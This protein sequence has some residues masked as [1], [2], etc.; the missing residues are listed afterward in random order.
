MLK[1]RPRAAKLKY[2]LVHEIS[3]NSPSGPNFCNVIGTLIR[4]QASL[5]NT[6]TLGHV[7]SSFIAR[8]RSD[9]TE[10]LTIDWPHE[11]WTFDHSLQTTDFPLAKLSWYS[12]TML[13]KYC[14]Y[15][16]GRLYVQT[17]LQKYLST[18]GTS[19]NV[20]WNIGPLHPSKI[21]YDSMYRLLC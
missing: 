9:A 12:D 8:D 1:P 15:I 13:V 7:D 5:E 2:W 21:A 20:V 17:Y 6:R 10:L 19:I 11:C 3:L 4:P 16:Y 14:L 18:Y